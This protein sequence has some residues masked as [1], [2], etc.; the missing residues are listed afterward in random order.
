M[1]IALV[2]QSNT[3]AQLKLQHYTY[4]LKKEKLITLEQILQIIEMTVNTY[5][6]YNSQFASASALILSR[7]VWTSVDGMLRTVWHPRPQACVLVRG[8][9]S[10]GSAV[11]L[12]KKVGFGSN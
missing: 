3:S 7:H 9:P 12:E 5:M 6:T 1:T 8:I 4:K 2:L 10:T 11:N